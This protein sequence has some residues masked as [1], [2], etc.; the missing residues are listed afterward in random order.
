M[1]DSADAYQGGRSEETLGKAL[2]GRW[3]KFVLATKFY[4]EGGPGPNDR[5]ASRYHIMNAVEA[6][7]RRLQSD[8]IRRLSLCQSASICEICGS[9]G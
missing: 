6:S 8:H 9:K 3:D 2:K 4:M 5:G 7:L 1:L